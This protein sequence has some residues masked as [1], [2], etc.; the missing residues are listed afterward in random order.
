MFRQFG[1]RQHIPSEGVAYAQKDLTPQ[2]ITKIERDLT[3]PTKAD[4]MFSRTKSFLMFDSS[5]T[6]ITE[7][8]WVKEAKRIDE[9]EEYQKSLRKKSKKKRKLKQNS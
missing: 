5:K 9:R 6:W 1:L 8:V 3:H 7:K 4:N 2:L